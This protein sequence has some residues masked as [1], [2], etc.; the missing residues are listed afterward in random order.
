[1]NLYLGIDG[2]G[3]KT[4]AIIINDSK[5]SLYEFTSGPS[6]CDTVTLEVTKENIEKAIAPFVKENPNAIF[7]GVFAGIG[8]IV[9]RKDIDA[10]ESIIRDLP[11]VT[12]DSVV[13]AR[14]DMETA[15]YSGGSFDQGMC[16]ICGTGMV[17]FG[18]NGKHAHKC[19]GWGYKEGELGSG[20]HLGREAIRHCIRA[21]DGRYP[22]NPFARD[23][24]NEIS[25]TRDKDIIQ[26]MNYMDGKRT[27]IANL[28]PIVTKH[29][30]LGN[31]YA[32]R[33]A[34][35]A[36]SE[37]ALA[38]AGVYH[39]LNLKKTTL[40]VVGSLGN[41]PGYFKDEL[42]KKIHHISSDIEIIESKIDP[43]LAA[44]LMA[45]K[46]ADKEEKS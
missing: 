13:L 43:A 20:Y 6:S 40:V 4:K 35:T 33:I 39:K 18:K 7:K 10:I 28:A 23:I 15:L 2:G 14:N 3:T 1:M 46:I 25:L 37:I 41:A 29:A 24:A 30:N 17:A 11:Q 5:E 44:A 27:M 26:I 12:K 19:G 9:F 31:V 8:G 42:H 34:D 21:Y 36:T 16:L 45:K 22:L 38:I 32:K